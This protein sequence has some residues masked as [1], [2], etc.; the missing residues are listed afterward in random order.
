MKARRRLAPVLGLVG[1]GAL[2]WWALRNAPPASDLAATLRQMGATG[3]PELKPG[4]IIPALSP[5]WQATLPDP[6][7]LNDP[8]YVASWRW[9][10]PPRS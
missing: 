10:P 1:L 2:L 8:E 7:R 3:E 6:S 5:A 9:A 4:R